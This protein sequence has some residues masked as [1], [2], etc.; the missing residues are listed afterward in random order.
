MN[1]TKSVLSSDN[2]NVILIFLNTVH[3]AGHQL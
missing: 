1:V 3:E 2:D